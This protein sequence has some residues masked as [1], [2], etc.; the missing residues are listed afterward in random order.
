MN[1]VESLAQVNELATNT[2]LTVWNFASDFLIIIVLCG[3]LFLFALYI[4]RATLMSIL[5]AF[6]AAYAVYIAFPYAEFLPAA[7]ALTALL[8]Q[9]GLYA[10]LTLAFYIIL[11]RG[12]LSAL[13]S[14]RP[15]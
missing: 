15:F 13:P 4:G 10:A 11:R 6:Y 3:I 5:L 2:A 14:T 1:A 8:A 12:A 7:P 9:V